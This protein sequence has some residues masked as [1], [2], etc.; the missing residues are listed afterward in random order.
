MRH[1]PDDF[2]LAGFAV[3]IVDEDKVPDPK[4][5]KPGDVV[6][7]LPSAGVH[8]SSLSLARKALFDRGGYTVDTK[9]EEFEE[10]LGRVVLTPTQLY[11]RDVMAF[12][13]HSKFTAAAH[14]TGGGLLGR[15][16]KL[17]IDG[18]R[19]VI[20]PATYERPAIFDVIQRAGD[21][22][23]ED[24]ARTFNLGLGFASSS[25]QR[26]LKSNSVSQRIHG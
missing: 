6:L 4:A 9:L 2:D 13:T 3:G 20:D 1:A 25:T 14:I 19:I 11:V 8:S 10:T 26:L 5:L 18:I 22:S 23:D 7:G 17:A 24:M 15:F 12:L 21:V 16:E